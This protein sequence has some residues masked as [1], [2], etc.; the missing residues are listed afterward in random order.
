MELIGLGN[1]V[2]KNLIPPCLERYIQ[3]LENLENIISI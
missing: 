1:N 2:E 3:N